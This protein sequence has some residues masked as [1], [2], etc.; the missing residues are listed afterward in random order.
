ME[1]ALLL[2][3]LKA[4]VAFVCSFTVTGTVFDD[5]TKFGVPS[6]NVVRYVTGLGPDSVSVP[7]NRD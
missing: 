5:T 6:D 3:Q 2:A 7:E 1:R 4:A